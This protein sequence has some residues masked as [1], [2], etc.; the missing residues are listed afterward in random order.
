MYQSKRNHPKY[1]KAGSLA[2]L[3]MSLLAV[4]PLSVASGDSAHSGHHS[5]AAAESGQDPHAHHRHM[6]QQR[7]YRRSEHDYQPPDLPL[8]SM[9]G[10]PTS[11][12]A[13]LASGKP[14]LLNFIFAT[15]T[16]ICPVLSASFSSVQEKL[17]SDRDQ[18]RMLS[19]TIDP[20]HDR[21]Q[22]LRDYAERFQAGSQWRFL[23]G[24]MNDI[25]AVQ[26]SFNAYWG[27]KS[28]H[29]PATFLRAEQGGPWVRLDGLASAAEILDE[30]HQLASR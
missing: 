11:L 16:T 18:V 24:E 3:G 4:Q 19:I 9:D 14:L 20:E 10:E 12:G 2:L 28:S 25:V 6:M 30:Y 22:Q 1:S 15:C 27:N 29:E 8:L 17:G 5:R 23:T 7:D 13:E 21:P 26:K